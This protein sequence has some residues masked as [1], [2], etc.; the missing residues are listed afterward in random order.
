MNKSD[1][2]HLMTNLFIIRGSRQIYFFA[3][4]NKL[5]IQ[6]YSSRIIANFIYKYQSISSVLAA[7]SAYCFLFEMRQQIR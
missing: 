2:S 4:V 1:I 7:P 6:S 3:R 5:I